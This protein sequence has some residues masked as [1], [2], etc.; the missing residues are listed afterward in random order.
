MR[1]EEVERH[2]DRARVRMRYPFAGRRIDAVVAVERRDGRWYLADFLRHA[3]AA[4]GP[5][6]AP[7]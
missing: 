3:E 5:A 7:R 1:V 2:G 6:G 4:A